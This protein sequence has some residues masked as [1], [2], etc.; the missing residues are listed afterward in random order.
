MGP[1]TNEGHFSI[2]MGPSPHLDGHHTIFGQVVAGW[3]VRE[4][5]VIGLHFRIE[6]NVCKIVLCLSVSDLRN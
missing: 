2:F 4:R 3:E 5:G 6:G 1:D